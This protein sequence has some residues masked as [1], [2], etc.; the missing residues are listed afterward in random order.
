MT[1]VIALPLPT[2]RQDGPVLHFLKETPAWVIILLLIIIFLAAWFYAHDDFIPRILDG[3]V[4]AMLTAIITQRPKPTA[5]IKTNHVDADSMNDVS[6][7]A[8]NLNVKK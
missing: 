4:G 3:L 1:E 7:T 8:A 5:N 2:P 6:V